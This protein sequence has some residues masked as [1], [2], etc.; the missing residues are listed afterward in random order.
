M[1][2]ISVNGEEYDIKDLSDEAVDHVKALQ[3]TTAEIN[4]LRA[5]LAAMETA[6]TAYGVALATIL[7]ADPETPETAQEINLPDNLIFD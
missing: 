4:A 2:R 3:F 6:H 7:E 1:A 5:K